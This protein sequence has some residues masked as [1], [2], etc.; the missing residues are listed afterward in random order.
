MHA[1]KTIEGVGFKALI[2]L[3]EPR[4]E[5][6]CRKTIMDEVLPKL[7]SSVKTGV[8]NALRD[9]NYFGLTFDYWNV[10]KL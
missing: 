5:I 1:I 6:P 3:L 4:Y 9:A 7:Y 8:L 2:K 10:K